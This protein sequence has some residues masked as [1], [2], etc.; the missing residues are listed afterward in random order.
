MIQQS[1][2]DKVLKDRILIIATM[3]NQEKVIPRN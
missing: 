3:Y 2:L 1:H